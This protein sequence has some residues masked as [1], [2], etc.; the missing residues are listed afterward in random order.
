MDE[1]QNLNQNIC[2]LTDQKVERLALSSHPPLFHLPSPFFLKVG[3]FL[4]DASWTGGYP[5]LSK[6]TPLTLTCEGY[7]E[8]GC[9]GYLQ[10]KKNCV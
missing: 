7:L 8:K 4:G 3:L 10:Q 9:S 6:E 2:L 1:D 5:S